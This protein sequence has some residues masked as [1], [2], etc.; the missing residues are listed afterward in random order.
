M[1]SLSN[2]IQIRARRVAV[3]IDRSRRRVSSRGGDSESL[4]DLSDN[5]PINFC[6]K[7]IYNDLRYDPAI[8]TAFWCIYSEKDGFQNLSIGL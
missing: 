1:I 7:N 3:C 6:I 8:I 5:F 4:D 2:T